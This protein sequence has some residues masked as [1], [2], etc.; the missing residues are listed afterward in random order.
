MFT[1]KILLSG[2]DIDFDTRLSLETAVR[3][4]G[5]EEILSQWERFTNSKTREEATA[6]AK[7]LLEIL[8]KKTSY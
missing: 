6:E 2:K 4:V 7:Y 1:E 8:I 5:D 3:D